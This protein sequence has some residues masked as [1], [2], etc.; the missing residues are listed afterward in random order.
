VAEG[1]RRGTAG[2]GCGGIRLEI[3]ACKELDGAWGIAEE[4]FPEDCKGQIAHAMAMKVSGSQWHDELSEL[5]TQT[6]G[7]KSPYWL[8]PFEYRAGR[9]TQRLGGPPG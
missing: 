7:S 1:A 3:I 5:G 9:R 8:R 6:N 4:R 2:D